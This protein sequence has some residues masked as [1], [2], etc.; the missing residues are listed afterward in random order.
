MSKSTYKIIEEIWNKI[1]QNRINREEFENK[2]INLLM[3]FDIDFIKENYKIL[4]YLDGDILK[5]YNYLGDNKRILNDLELL[6]CLSLNR[7][8][9]KKV[10]K[11]KKELATFRYLIHIY[12]LDIND[13]QTV[14]E[15]LNR[16]CREIDENYNFLSENNTIFKSK[17]SLL[18]ALSLPP[19]ELKERYYNIINNYDDKNLHYTTYLQT[20]VENQN[21]IFKKGINIF[22]K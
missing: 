19:D 20:N 10:F 17:R 8:I 2:I 15:L 4:Y 22:K 7:D 16:H 11:S 3:Y 1:D 12:C 18:I 5:N 9:L 14:P 13:I 21:E 6:Y